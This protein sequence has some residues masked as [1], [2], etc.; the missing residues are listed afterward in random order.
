MFAS[1]AGVHRQRTQ[2]RCPTKGPVGRCRRRPDW[3][4]SPDPAD[5]AAASP[6]PRQIDE[7]VLALQ[8]ANGVIVAA[9]DIS[10]DM[11]VDSGYSKF[12]N[13]LYYR[14][15][16]CCKSDMGSRG[17]CWLIQCIE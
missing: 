6:F 9:L 15:D 12:T 10:H 5:R 4:Q 11:L 17:C 1:A 3:F 13:G 8:A 7:R 2:R 16:F 14:A